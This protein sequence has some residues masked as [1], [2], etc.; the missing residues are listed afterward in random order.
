MTPW[1]LIPKRLKVP[2]VFYFILGAE[3][4]RSNTKNEEEDQELNFDMLISNNIIEGENRNFRHQP[5]NKVRG[6]ELFD[7]ANITTRYQFYNF[8]NLFFYKYY[9]NENITSEVESSEI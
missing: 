2:I 3:F 7:K 8:N 9:W 1:E 5:T 6:T 4:H